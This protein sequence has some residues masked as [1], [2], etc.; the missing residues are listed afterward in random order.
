M[1]RLSIPPIPTLVPL[2]PIGVGPLLFSALGC[3]TGRVLRCRTFLFCLV[4]SRF[5]CFYFSILLLTLFPLLPIGVG[6]FLFS[7]L[8]RFTGRVLRC[9]TFLFCLVLSRLVCFYFLIHL[10]TPNPS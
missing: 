4:L 7:V 8:R 9:R 2:L 6:P 5:V 3:F 1:I 10:L